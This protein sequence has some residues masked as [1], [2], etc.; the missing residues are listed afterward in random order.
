MN[1]DNHSPSASAEQTPPPDRKRAFIHNVHRVR[2]ACKWVIIALLTGLVIG[3]VGIAFSHGMEWAT[4]MRKSYPYLLFGLPIAG[5]IIVSLYYL[6]HDKHNRGTN[7][8]ISAIH[9]GE[10]VPFHVA[11]IMFIAT[12]L[13]HLC[14]GSA[15]REGAA[16]QIGASIGNQIG[17]L[18]RFNE[19]DQRVMIMCGMSA[20]F[21]A[22]FG[23]P[24]AAAIFSMEVISVGVMY[25]AALVPCVLSA[26]VAHAL[27]GRFGVTYETFPL[28]DIPAF[29]VPNAGLVIVL[30]I[31]CAVLSILFCEILH[32]TAHFF[33]ERISNHFL[34][35]ITGGCIIIVLTLLVG[36]NDYNG[37]GMD[38]IEHCFETGE[39][40]PFAFV[41]KMIFTA[42]TL[43]CCFKGGEIV[44]TFY[45]GA[46]FGCLFAMI[47]GFDAQMCIAIGMGSLFCG[48]TNSPIASLLICFELFGYEGMPFFL[49]A[50]SFSYML[51]G[52]RGLYSSQKILYSKFKT[53]Y[54]GKNT[55]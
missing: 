22:L 18:F 2:T 52:Y 13:T 20:C 29:T 5:I 14:G 32:R 27:A 43:G 38:V 36:T 7:L 17:K 25:Y 6:F 40:F 21:A 23:T 46:T 51:S 1:Q 45:V 54:M 12:I 9:S 42:I 39:V 3:A 16:L 8:V 53:T 47:T 19:N 24:M 44:P 50:I 34:R 30:S 41:L 10:E 4:T 15:G 31:L 11:P 49:L 26:L 37:A 35:A 48:V 28:H 55:R 33:R